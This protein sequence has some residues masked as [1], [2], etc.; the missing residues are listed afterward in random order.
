MPAAVVSLQTD[1]RRFGT[2][3]L[4]LFCLTF[5]FIARLEVSDLRL[6]NVHIIKRI[7]L[8]DVNRKAAQ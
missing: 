3:H 2:F 8:P 6:I 4:L 5:F 1:A 7:S